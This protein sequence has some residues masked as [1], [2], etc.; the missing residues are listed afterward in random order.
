MDLAHGVLLL[1]IGLFLTFI[2]FAIILYAESPS[3]EEELTEV[4]KQLKDLF[5]FRLY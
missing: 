2:V 3:K 5:H 1:V 4:Q